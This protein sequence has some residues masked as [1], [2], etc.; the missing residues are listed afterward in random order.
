MFVIAKMGIIQSCNN[1]SRNTLTL[2]YIVSPILFAYILTF[3]FKK[4]RFCELTSENIKEINADNSGFL[5]MILGYIFVGL[6][7]NNIYALLVVMGF[8]LIF[9]MAGNS[10][11]YN[12]IFYLF[13]YK[14]Y[15]VTSTDRIKILIMSKQRIRLGDIVTFPEVH[16]LNDYT[17]IDISKQM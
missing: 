5:A 3:F 10:Y 16:C 1:I 14:Y 2:I 15:Y 17:Y 13:G 7:I 6:S 11:I 12:P 4:L 8:L 9:N